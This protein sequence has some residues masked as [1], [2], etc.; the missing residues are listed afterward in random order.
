MKSIK[1]GNMSLAFKMDDTNYILNLNKEEAES[2]IDGSSHTYEIQM[3]ANNRMVTLSKKV[4][5]GGEPEFKIEGPGMNEAEQLEFVRN[6]LAVVHGE[7]DQILGGV[8]G[9][10]AP[11][12]VQ[13]FFMLFDHFFKEQLLQGLDNMT[14]GGAD[15]EDSGSEDEEGM[16]EEE[17]QPPAMDG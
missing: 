5:N 9:G 16:E 7:F 1:R 15:E 17:S 10:Q 2:D 6:W 4:L 14:R 8:S 11:E 12:G 3:Q 13:S